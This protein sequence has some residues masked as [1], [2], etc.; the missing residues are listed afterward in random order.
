MDDMLTICPPLTKYVSN[1]KYVYEHEL[2]GALQKQTNTEHTCAAPN[3]GIIIYSETFRIK[4]FNENAYALVDFYC[5]TH[6]HT[7]NNT[8]C[9]RSIFTFSCVYVHPTQLFLKQFNVQFLFF[10]YIYF[11]L[12]YEMSTTM[13]IYHTLTTTYIVC[14]APYQIRVQ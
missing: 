14:C 11:S 5:Y 3:D 1:F 2:Q 6:T 8:L 13:Y 4:T 9:A 12:L 10:I 7:M